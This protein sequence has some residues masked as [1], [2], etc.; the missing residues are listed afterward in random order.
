[1][2]KESRSSLL[3][4]GSCGRGRNKE[5]D[6]EI[7]QTKYKSNDA[8]KIPSERTFKDPK[9]MKSQRSELLF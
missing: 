4:T 7:L 2:L 1:M 3:Q 5:S 6:T 8:K 9:C